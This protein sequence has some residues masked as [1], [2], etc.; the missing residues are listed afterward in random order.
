MRYTDLK[1]P[2]EEEFLTFCDNLFQKSLIFDAKNR[3]KSKYVFVVHAV[4]LKALTIFSYL[5]KIFKCKEY[6][7]RQSMWIFEYKWIKS[8]LFENKK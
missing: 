3:Q 6:T 1:T 4:Y 2:T 5:R 8:P 7:G